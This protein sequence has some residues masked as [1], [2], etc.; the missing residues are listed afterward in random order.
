MPFRPENRHT[1][2]SLLALVVGIMLAGAG[3]LFWLAERQDARFA[4]R[5]LERES[6]DRAYA[7]C[8]TEFASDLVDTLEARTEAAARLERASA[9]KDRTLDRL[10]LITE[11]ARRTPPEATAA[12]FDRVLDARVA[13]QDRYDRI[14]DRLAIVR[15]ENEYVRPE[16]VCSR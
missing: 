1:T 12:Q 8:L 4:D 6:A 15:E 9:A 5:A 10:L 7:D 3:I 14:A 16:V 13:A 11:L 2:L